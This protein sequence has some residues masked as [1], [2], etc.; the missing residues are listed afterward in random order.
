MADKKIPPHSASHLQVLFTE[1]AKILT[2]SLKVSEVINALMQ[3]VQLF[4]KPKNWSVLRL[5]PNK[6][7]LYFVLSK[8]IKGNLVKN[9]RLKLDEGIAG[10]VATTGKAKIVMNAQLDPHFSKKVDEVSGFKTR[11]IIAVPIIFQGVVLGVI[12]L[13]NTHDSRL[14][15]KRELSILHTIADF[16]AIAL[17][18]AMRYEK[19]LKLADTDSLTGL[20][21]RAY[22]DK[23]IFIN[24]EKIKNKRKAINPYVIVVFADVN[25]LKKTNDKYG[26]QAG[27]KILCETAKYLQAC[28]R[29][30]DYAFRIG[31][32]EFLIILTHLKK[33]DVPKLI[34]RLRARLL[35]HVSPIKSAQGFSF[36]ITHG[37][38]KDLEQL[39]KDADT[40]MYSAKKRGLSCS[41]D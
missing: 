36:G 21:N 24:K 9:I 7:E 41:P 26:H 19:I 25:K 38:K 11:S 31:G 18:N 28:C 37:L 4:F 22:L 16:F 40:A 32:D 35:N 3:Q 5:D 1:T 15:T 12:E 23:L 17:T 10:Y 27:D 30:N 13:L 34:K 2:S 14:F 33:I 29:L 39:I 6:Q 20:Y 8:G